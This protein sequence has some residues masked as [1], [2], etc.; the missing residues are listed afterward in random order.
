MWTALILVAAQAGEEPPTFT[1]DVAPILWQSCAAC[2]RPGEVAPFAL[3][4]YAD[5]KKRASQI[6]EV[7]D[8]GLMPPWIPTA[9][10]VPFAGE[11]RLSERDKLTLR[12]WAEQGAPEGSPAD[13]P[14]AP[15]FPEGWQ[16]GTPDLVVEMGEAFTAPAE[17]A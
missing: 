11:R 16:L 17:G 7:I 15:M 14:A 9:E 13:L 5:A 8:A 6:V 2:H 4:S 3:L 1:R 12:T 10:S